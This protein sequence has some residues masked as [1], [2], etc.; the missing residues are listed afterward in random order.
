MLIYNPWLCYIKRVVLTIFG[1]VI[2]EKKNLQHCKFNNTM[3]LNLKK[4]K[5]GKYYFVFSI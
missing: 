4:F 3:H 5:V 2:Q 1:R